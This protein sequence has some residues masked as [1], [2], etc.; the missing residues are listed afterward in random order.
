MPDFYLVRCSD[1]VVSTFSEQGPGKWLMSRLPPAMLPKFRHVLHCGA[2]GW[3]VQD[4]SP[5]L[6]SGGCIAVPDTENVHQDSSQPP[7]GSWRSTDGRTEFTL[8][9]IRP[10]CPAL[11]SQMSIEVPGIRLTFTRLRPAS[12]LDIKFFNRPITDG[13]LD[14]LL[15]WGKSLLVELGRRPEMTVMIITDLTEA[16]VPAMRHVKRFMAWAKENGEIMNLP[17]RGNAIVLRPGGFVGQALVSIIKMIQRILQAAWPETLVPTRE[18]ADSFLAQHQP[19]SDFVAAEPDPAVAV[20]PTTDT[21]VANASTAHAPAVVGNSFRDYEQQCSSGSPG[22]TVFSGSQG[23]AST[24][25]PPSDSELTSPQPLT[26]VPAAPDQ[27][28]RR[29]QSTSALHGRESGVSSTAYRTSRQSGA[30]NGKHRSSR[31]SSIAPELAQLD[32]PVWVNMGYRPGPRLGYTHPKV[33]DTEVIEPGAQSMTF[34]DMCGG[35][36]RGRRFPA[37]PPLPRR[38]IISQFSV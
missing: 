14:K 27:K 11:D 30:A 12:R 1:G 10:M 17:I 2:K 32:V 21:S 15:V 25:A 9:Q 19:S 29:C 34:L 31:T 38:R 37:T 28:N 16:S 33:K 5:G 4:Q 20:P 36:S 35:C 22:S 6:H 7:V 13:C 23:S 24:T 18:E 8:T 3:M 26:T